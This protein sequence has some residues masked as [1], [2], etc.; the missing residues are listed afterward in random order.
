MKNR[1][2]TGAL[3]AS[4]NIHKC[5]GADRRFDPERVAAVIGEIGADVI[6]LQEVDRRFGDKAGL[7]DLDTL[8]RRT[9]LVPVPVATAHAGHGWHGNA[10]LVREGL[11]RDL[12]QV[13]LPGLEPRGALVADLDL[14][15]GS[16]RVVA[17]HLGLLRHSRLLQVE[18]LALHAGDADGRPVV[19][20]GDLNEWRR[21]RSLGARALRPGVR[22]A[23]PRGADLSV[24]VSRCCRS[25]ASWRRR[26]ASWD[27]SRR[28]RARW[29]AW[30]RTTCRSRRGCGWT[31]WRRKRRRCRRAR[32]G[33]ASSA[34]CRGGGARRSP[35]WRGRACD[36]IGRTVAVAAALVMPAGASGAVPFSRADQNRDGL[37]SFEEARRV[38]PDL[39]RVHFEKCD[40]DG[41]GVIDHGEFALLDNFYTIMYV[42]RN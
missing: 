12:H 40:P 23:R 10:V 1:S 35:S 25:T 13:T 18:A 2:A 24:A 21:A 4:Y 7:L 28:T 6:A 29:R 32:P 38:F 39:A 20:M 34:C 42:N 3:F 37:V 14:V 27:G 11:V 36:A 33:G 22:P 9:G 30:P 16:V 8:G 26:S 41:D 5:V 17:A 15:P 19:L 31:A